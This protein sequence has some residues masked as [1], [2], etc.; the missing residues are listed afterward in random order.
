MTTNSLR[1]GTLYFGEQRLGFS[2]KEVGTHFI[3]SEFSMEIYL[4][5][6]YHDHGTMGKHRL[7]ALYP[8]P[9]Q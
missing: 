5:K 4:D 1:E 2:H 6:V 7:P 3:W 9:G 8:H